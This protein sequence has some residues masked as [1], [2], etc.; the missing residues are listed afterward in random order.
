MVTGAVL[1]KNSGINAACGVATRAGRFEVA[2]AL[3]V[4]ESV[5]ALVVAAGAETGSEVGTRNVGDVAVL[6]VVAA[7]E[8]P[9]ASAQ[10]FD[11]SACIYDGS[12]YVVD[13]ARSRL[14]IG[15]TREGRTGAGAAIALV[16]CQYI[17]SLLRRSLCS[18]CPNARRTQTPEARPL[19][20]VGSPGHKALRLLV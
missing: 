19:A 3:E 2:G 12:P 9:S 6:P 15:G 4:G 18:P 5:A 20:L 13:V 14:G 10:L 7:G 8:L 17:C 1:N 11:S 16:T